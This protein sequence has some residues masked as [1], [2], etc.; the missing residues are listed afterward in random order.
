MRLFMILARFFSNTENNLRCPV[1]TI[2]RGHPYLN[3]PRLRAAASPPQKKT[4]RHFWYQAQ[5]KVA[6]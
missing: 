5:E 3:L 4:C 2:L 6:L 1:T